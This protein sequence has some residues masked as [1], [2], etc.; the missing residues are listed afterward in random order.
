MEPA[1]VVTGRPDEELVLP[2]VCGSEHRM[3]HINEKTQNEMVPLVELKRS[4]RRLSS[5]NLTIRKRRYP[6]NLTDHSITAAADILTRD[7]AAP[8]PTKAGRA[9]R[10]NEPVPRR[11]T[12]IC[13]FPRSES[14][15]PSKF[16]SAK[17]AVD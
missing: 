6:A 15:H 10:Q 14:T 9:A 7:R 3:P 5:P 16:V 1:I 11:S 17:I 13:V 12:W 8:L 4:E 2:K